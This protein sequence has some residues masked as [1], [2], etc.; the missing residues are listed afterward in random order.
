M[1]FIPDSNSKIKYGKLPFFSHEP[2]IWP[3]TLFWGKLKLKR[4]K[5]YT[6]W[7]LRIYCLN[8]NSHIH[9]LK[10]E[11]QWV[12]FLNVLISYIFINKVPIIISWKT[13][14]CPYIHQISLHLLMRNVFPACNFQRNRDTQHSSHPIFYIKKLEKKSIQCLFQL[15]QKVFLNYIF[16]MPE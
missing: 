9:I 1:Y 6:F 13:L 7:I 14:L 11:N 10:N 15:T 5:K 3:V 4:K 16:H 12:T 2:V 8:V